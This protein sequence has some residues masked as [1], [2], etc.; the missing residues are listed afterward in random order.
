MNK[1]KYALVIPAAASMFLGACADPDTAA[2]TD[3]GTEAQSGVSAATFDVSTIE[4][5]PEIAAMVPDAI[6]QKGTLSNGVSADF[7]P[8]EFL[9]DDGQTPI[10]YDVTLIAAIAQV[11][12]LKSNSEH[13]DF[14]TIL[15]QLGTKFDVAASSFTITPE[16][17]EQVNMI[18]YVNVGSAFAVAKGNPNKFDPTQPCGA[19]IAVQNGTYQQEFV[20][21]LSEDCVKDGQPEIKV[22]PHDLQTEIAPKVIGGQYDATFADSPVIGYTVKQANGELEQVGDQIEAEPQGIAVA[23]DNAEFAAAVQK[24]VQYLM[25]KGYMAQILGEYGAQDFALKTAELNPAN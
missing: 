2:M 17:L 4:T 15:P 24:A 1:L 7:A 13:A 12:G 6:K 23:K 8:A 9:A 22:M 10:G 16:R 5:V 14:A 18:S 25:D 20:T 21:K 19:T 11:M 3:T